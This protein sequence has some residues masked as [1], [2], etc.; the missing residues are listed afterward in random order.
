M[1]L[2]PTVRVKLSSEAAESISITPVVVQEMPIRELVEYMLGVTGKDGP[3][4]RELLLRGSLV[5][6]ASR[7]RWTGWDAMLEDLHELLA[8]FPDPEP[9]RRFAAAKCTHASLRGGRQSI[10]ISREAG[11]RK[12]LFQRQSFWDALMKVTAVATPVY[13]DYSYRE[14]CDRY[15]R[16]FTADELVQLRTASEMVRYTTLSDQIRTVA[17]THA[18]FYVKREA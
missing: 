11:M 3:R 13:S 8:T 14:R 1:A 9:S 2:P 15:L 6:G 16:E 5:S 12:G 10:E 4:I 17:F 18:E 7:F